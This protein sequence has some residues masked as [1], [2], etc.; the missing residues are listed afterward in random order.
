MIAMPIEEVARGRLVGFLWRLGFR[1]ITFLTQGYRRPL[2]GKLV[3]DKATIVMQAVPRIVKD[4]LSEDQLL[5]P[6]SRM[7][8]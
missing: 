3:Q 7:Y 2:T 5:F 6:L 1:V 8:E 4:S